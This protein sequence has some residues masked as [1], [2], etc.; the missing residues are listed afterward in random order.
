MHIPW[1]INDS[2]EECRSAMLMSQAKIKWGLFWA[3]FIEI[4]WVVVV[5]FVWPCWQTNQPISKHWWKHNLL[6]KSEKHIFQ[7]DWTLKFLNRIVRVKVAF[8]YLYIYLF[9]S[10]GQQKQS[11]NTTLICRCIIFASGPCCVLR[12]IGMT[13]FGCLPV[14]DANPDVS[15]ADSPWLHRQSSNGNS[16]S[17]LTKKTISVAKKFIMSVYYHI[18]YLNVKLQCNWHCQFKILTPSPPPLS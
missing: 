18:F 1:E 13:F 12:A 3:S 15:I 8:I 17:G 16:F 10:R 9:A 6:G 7:A 14:H 5:V 11:V 4:Y 2:V